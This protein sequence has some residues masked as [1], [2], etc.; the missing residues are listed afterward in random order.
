M[1]RIFRC[2]IT[3]IGDYCK[4]ISDNSYKKENR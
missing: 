3:K 2:E 4:M 1:W